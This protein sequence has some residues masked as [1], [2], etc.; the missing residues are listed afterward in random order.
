MTVRSYARSRELLDRS[1]QFLAG[2]V[3]SAV[4][5][6]D[7]PFP[8]FYQRGVGSR[9]FDVDGNEY[10]D[11]VLGR[12]P[13]ILG[14][15]SPAI[16]GAV[17]AQL[18]LGQIYAGEHELEIELSEKLCR[19]IPCA[20]LVRYSVTGSEA[21][22]AALRLARAYTQ[23]E[24]IV[25]FEGH[26]H[27]WLDNI[28]FSLAPSIQEAGPPDNPNAIAG[29][30]GQSVA[31]LAHVIVLPWNDLEIL[32]RTVQ[33][34]AHEIAA[35]IMEPIM[36]NT[37]VIMPQRGYL[38]GVREI[39][40]RYGIIL[41][42]DEVI[43]GF[44]VSLGGAQSVFKVT[45]DLAV[46]GKAIAAGFPL[47]CLVG[48]RDVMNLIATGNVVHSGTFNSHPISMAAGVRAV[49][50]LEKDDSR[51][52]VQMNRRGCH[53]MEGI[54]EKAR[55][56]GFPL[57]VQGHGTVFFV[58]F[59]VEPSDACRLPTITDYRTSLAVDMSWYQGFA[60]AMSDRGVRLIQRGLWFLSAAHTDEDIETT[61]AAVEDS[62]RAVGKG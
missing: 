30:L 41:I 53:L 34:R 29:S 21:V 48:K 60:R 57:I 24:L 49:E 37:G 50:E 56:Q 19:I 38:E 61:L 18:D 25:K 9:L 27:G 11:Y 3:S 6:G 8:L 45:P 15:S 31:D 46:F 23:R 35:L 52:Y 44:R 1:K 33:A 62:L 51:L 4:R 2:G 54:R 58:A 7:M 28:F 59:P 20:E 32:Q 14:H 43:T 55:Q 42:F 47:S 10:I 22:Q 13:L 17:K 16:I 12:G 5:A 39:C 36:C 40:S 26:Y